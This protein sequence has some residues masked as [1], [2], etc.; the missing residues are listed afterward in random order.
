MESTPIRINNKMKKKAGGNCGHPSNF[1]KGRTAL[2]ALD[3]VP[4]TKAIK[5]KKKI[6]T[7]Y[8]SPWEHCPFCNG[9]LPLDDKVIAEAKLRGETVYT[10]DPGW[11]VKTCP[12]CGAYEISQCPACKGKTWYD[13]KTKMYKHQWK[14]CGFVGTKKL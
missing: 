7:P 3:E 6:K 8:V 4:R 14:H 9:K 11:R 5:R 13:P 1:E 2:P 12:S 10:W